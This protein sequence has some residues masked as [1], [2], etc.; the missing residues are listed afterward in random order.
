MKQDNHSTSGPEQAVTESLFLLGGILTGALSRATGK[1]AHDNLERIFS[2]SGRRRLVESVENGRGSHSMRHG[3][4][5]DESRATPR[6][7]EQSSERGP[8]RAER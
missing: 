1:S 6:G 4:K 8:K 3:E 7:E 5:C 2:N